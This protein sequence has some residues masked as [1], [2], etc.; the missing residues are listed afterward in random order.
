MNKSMLISIPQHVDE[1]NYNVKLLSINL[2]L[3]ILGN[4][5]RF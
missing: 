2:I 1:I 4:Q 3:F 5:N